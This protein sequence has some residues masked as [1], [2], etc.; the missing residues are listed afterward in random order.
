MYL[1]KS[2]SIHKHREREREREREEQSDKE[3][4][5]PL[6]EKKEVDSLVSFPSLWLSLPVSVRSPKKES[7]LVND[8]NY[9]DKWMLLPAC[10]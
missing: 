5:E 9:L 1:R 8:L 6:R 10:Q 3:K 2:W 4:K 7:A